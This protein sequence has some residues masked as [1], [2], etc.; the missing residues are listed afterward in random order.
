MSEKKY[1]FW[2][3]EI[4]ALEHMRESLKSCISDFNKKIEKGLFPNNTGYCYN[5]HTPL[6]IYDYQRFQHWVLIIKTGEDTGWRKHYNEYIR[7]KTISYKLICSK[8]KNNKELMKKLA[9]D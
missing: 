7:T 6:S 8:C 5:C 9:S 4:G 1:D 3:N 2:G